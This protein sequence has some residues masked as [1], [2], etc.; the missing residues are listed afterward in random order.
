M[1]KPTLSALFPILLSLSI[2]FIAFCAYLLTL[3]PTITWAHGGADSGELA[4]AVV[5]NGVAH[6]PGYPT[7]LLVG[8]LWLMLPL[9]ED[10]AYQLN[11]LSA[12]STALAAGLTAQTILWLAKSFP[13][14]SIWQF[15]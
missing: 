14:L 10:A 6:P 13:T 3:A 8:S 1:K 4:A 12:I 11:L 9:A 15:E 5:T 2:I 7:Y